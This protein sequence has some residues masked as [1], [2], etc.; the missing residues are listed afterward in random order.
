MSFMR[1]NTH[2]QQHTHFAP[3]ILVEGLGG[4]PLLDGLEVVQ[5]TETHVCQAVRAQDQAR[6]A[7]PAFL[8]GVVTMGR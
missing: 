7:T 3:K 2:K 5:R 1:I 8:V 4:L 6:P